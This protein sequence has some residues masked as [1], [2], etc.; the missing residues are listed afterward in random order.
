MF[1]S[2]GFASLLQYPLAQWASGTCHIANNQ[3]IF[4]EIGQWKYVN[5]LLVVSMLISFSFAYFDFHRRD[6]ANQVENFSNLYTPDSKANR[7]RTV[8]WNNQS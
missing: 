6:K 4:C 3:E 1:I 8:S 7:N 2:G 5:M